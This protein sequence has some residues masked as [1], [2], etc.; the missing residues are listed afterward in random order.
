M[1][2]STHET[3]IWYYYQRR[4]SQPHR[5]EICSYAS[6]NKWVPVSQTVLRHRVLCLKRNTPTLGTV[7]KPVQV[8]V[9]DTVTLNGQISDSSW[10]Q[11]GHGKAQDQWII[12]GSKSFP[13]V[14]LWACGYCNN[15]RFAQLRFEDILTVYTS[16]LS[17]GVGLPKLF[18]K[19]TSQQH[20]QAECVKAG[21]GHLHQQVL[22]KPISFT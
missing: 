13:N 12:V 14:S 18:I 11:V 16:T 9:L 3:W 21:F 7:R 1:R 10:S 22:W 6:L 19:S 20:L 4:L 2:K 5:W 8:P 17:Q 15:N